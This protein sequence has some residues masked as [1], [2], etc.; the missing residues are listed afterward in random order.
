MM[1][2]AKGVGVGDGVGSRTIINMFLVSQVSGLVENFNIWIFSDT[3]NVMNVKLFK[4]VL[5]TDPAVGS[6]RR[7]S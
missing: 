4:V 3:M 6:C 5:H 2:Y 1:N 7:K